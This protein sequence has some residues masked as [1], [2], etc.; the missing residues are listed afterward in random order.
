IP[1]LKLA[2]IDP[3]DDDRG[4]RRGS[5]RGCGFTCVCLVIRLGGWSI[6]LLSQFAPRHRSGRSAGCDVSIAKRQRF[7]TLARLAATTD[8]QTDEADSKRDGAE[9]AG[10]HRD[11]PWK[12]C[13]VLF[14]GR[15]VF[16]E[17][18]KGSVHVR[19]DFAV[20]RSLATMDLVVDSPK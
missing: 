16:A 9:W 13:G 20:F 2:G 6:E 7:R 8:G 14:G 10:H 17:C 12:R 4:F 11:H 3:A 15:N 1:R 5:R 19:F 18:R